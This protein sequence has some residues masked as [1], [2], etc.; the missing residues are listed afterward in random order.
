[1]T[2]NRNRSKVSRPIWEDCE[3]ACQAV[4]AAPTCRCSSMNGGFHELLA[5]EEAVR[6]PN[7][8]EERD[9]IARQVLTKYPFTESMQAL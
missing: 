2:L 6:Q 7:L 1:M 4:D 8:G 9:S 3:S 5:R